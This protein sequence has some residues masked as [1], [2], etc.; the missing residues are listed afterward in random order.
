MS[1]DGKTSN[2]SKNQINQLEKRIA[3]IE[4]LIPTLESEAAELTRQMSLPDI[5]ADFER[6]NTLAA[7]HKALET[8]IQ[9]LYNEWDKA[10]GELGN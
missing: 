8:R 4:K 5:A 6:L 1:Y 2:L 3:E 7:E 9:D 10:A